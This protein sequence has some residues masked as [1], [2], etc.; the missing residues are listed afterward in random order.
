MNRQKFVERKILIL[1]QNQIELAC[2]L[3]KNVPIDTKSPIEV[4]VREKQK[5]RKL[6]QN[7]RYW[8]GPLKDIAE[9]AWVDG[10]QFSDIVWHEFFKKEFLPEEHDQELCKEKYRK[11]A[12]TP[13]GD[14]FLIGSTTDLTVKGFA[15]YMEQVYAAGADLGVMFHEQEERG[16]R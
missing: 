9:Q 5:A 4:V 15:Q 16:G 2:N 7:A 3:L 11:W 6:D 10:K 1:S 12:F 8:A 13:A 14:K